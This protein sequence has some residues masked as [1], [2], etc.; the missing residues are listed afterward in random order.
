MAIFLKKSQNLVTGAHFCHKNPLYNL[1]WNF[2]LST[3]GEKSQKED[4]W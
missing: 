2:L 3:H 1:H 4:H